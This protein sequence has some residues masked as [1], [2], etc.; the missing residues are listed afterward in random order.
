MKICVLGAS[1][2]L[3]IAGL[4][5]AGLETQVG[6]GSPTNPGGSSYGTR[7]VLWDNGDT[8]GSNGYSELD[9]GFFG[10]SRSTLDDFV[11]TDPA[12]WNISDFHD[13]VLYPSGNPLAGVG[14]NLTFRA[15]AGGTPG[16]VL[17]PT[18][19]TSYT[20]TVTGRNWFGIQETRIDVTFNPIFL[21]PGRY[22]IEMQNISPD[23]TFHMVRSAV[24]GSEAWVNYQDFPPMMPGSSLFGVAADMS[25][26]LTGDVAPAPAGFAAAAIAGLA[27]ARRRR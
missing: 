22:W 3:A 2:V 17:G 14:Y 18:T 7:S 21:G 19:N 9:V 8:D 10:I 16:A 27:L 13:L 15:D 25:Y 12:G 11:I 24:T 20:Q 4:A 1:S 5:S 23:N 26:V 6:P